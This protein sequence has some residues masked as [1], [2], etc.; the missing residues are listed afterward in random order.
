[1]KISDTMCTSKILT[2]LYLVKQKAK[3]KNIYI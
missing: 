2:D 1:M 3:T